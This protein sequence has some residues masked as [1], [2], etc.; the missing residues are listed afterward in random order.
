MLIAVTGLRISEALG[1]RWEDVDWLGKRIHLRRGWV[2]ETI[3]ESLKTEGSKRPVPLS[4]VLAES[5]KTWRAETPYAQSRD[6]IFASPRSKGRSPRSASVLI[7]D[8]LRPAAIAAGV[9]LAPGQRFGFHN[10][11]HSLATFLVNKGADVKTV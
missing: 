8:H 2:G 11:R 10:L 7:A 6:W 1:L 9:D 3:V 4:D 5:L